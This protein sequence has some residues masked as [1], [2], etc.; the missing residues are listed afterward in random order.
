MRHQLCC[1]CSAKPC[2]CP[3][4]CMFRFGQ[5]CVSTIPDGIYPDFPRIHA[6]THTFTSQALATCYNQM[7]TKLFTHI[8]TRNYVLHKHIKIYTHNHVLHTHKNIHTYTHL[9]IRSTCTQGY[10]HTQSR[11]PHAHSNMHT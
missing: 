6:H 11:A 2:S 5:D 1:V 4:R 7:H 3:K 9:S 8:H 10:T